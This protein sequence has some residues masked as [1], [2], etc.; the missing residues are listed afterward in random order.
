M[1]ITLLRNLVLVEPI[2]PESKIIL[3]QPLEHP[4][5]LG[6]VI[7]VGRGKFGKQ[8][9]I[10]MDVSVGD[11]VAFGKAIGEPTKLDGQPHLVMFEDD[12][13]AVVA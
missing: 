7:A 13:M 9:R 2:E 1:N 8:G 6:K 4:S 3:T 5:R 10:P 11:T 12:I